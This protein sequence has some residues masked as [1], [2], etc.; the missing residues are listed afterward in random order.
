MGITYSQT[1]IARLID[2]T[3]RRIEACRAKFRGHTH[4][5]E[6]IAIVMNLFLLMLT[7]IFDISEKWEWEWTHTFGRQ[8]IEH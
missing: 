6:V 3:P 5:I 1:K 2:S 8:Y 4:T 7:V